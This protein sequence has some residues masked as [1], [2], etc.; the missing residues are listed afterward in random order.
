MGS[1]G[2]SGMSGLCGYGW[3]RQYRGR[4]LDSRTRR[5]SCEGGSRAGWCQ[6]WNRCDGRLDASCFFEE[7]GGGD[8]LVNA[9]NSSA[10]VESLPT[11]EYIV[12]VSTNRPCE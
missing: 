4:N 7:A 6:G 5:R 12:K 9:K 2:E 11:T 8:K 10:T 3:L 1:R